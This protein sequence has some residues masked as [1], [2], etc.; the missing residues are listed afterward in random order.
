MGAA[1]VAVAVMAL[2]LVYLLVRVLG[3]GDSAW[4]ALWRTKTLDTV[5]TTIVLVLLVVIGALILAAP[6][7]WLLSRTDIPLRGPFLVL[8]ALPL[9]VPSYV[10]AYAWIA[11]FPGMSGIFAAA[12]VMALCTFPYVSIPL[13]AVLRGMDAGQEEAARSLGLGPAAV[14]R[15]VVVPMAWPAAAAGL[16]LVALYSIA[17]FGTVAIFRV[18]A[19]T[20]VIYASYRASFD[21]TTAAV[22]AILLV[23]LALALVA[24]EARMRGR[25]SRWRI[26]SGTGRPAPLSTL[27]RRGRVLGLGWLCLVTLLALVVPLGSIGYQLLVSQ[28]REIDAGALAGAVAG[29]ISSATLGAVVALLL[30]IPVGVLAARYTGRWVRS[31]EAGAFLG[32]GLPGVVVGLSLV[33]LTLAVVPAAYQTLAALAFAYAVLFAPKAIGATRTSVA[34]V[35]PELESVARSLGRGPIHAW[36]TTTGRIAWPGI[37]AGGLLVLL[38]AMKELPATL[39]LRPTGFETLATRL[40]SRTEVG[41]FGAAAPYALALIAL[42]AIPAWLMGRWLTRRSPGSVAENVEWDSVSVPAVTTPAAGSKA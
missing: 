33:F 10:A 9:A 6:T 26:G 34:A 25:A 24:A 42:A 11:I 15:R 31:L 19:F 17:E 2:P 35:P 21:R 14:V 27:S 38:T 13:V 8:M 4:S 29:S 36:W 16:L 12:L 30:A 22:L 20:R 3:A 39:M 1:V 32:H 7:A 28:R 41:A 40:W 37:A 23:V 18:D 5:L